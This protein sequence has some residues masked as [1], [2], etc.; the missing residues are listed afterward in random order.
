MVCGK[1]LPFR[2]V[3]GCSAL[4]GAD[5]GYM[6]YKFTPEACLDILKKEQHPFTK[7]SLGVNQITKAFNE[8]LAKLK[9][10]FADQVVPNIPMPWKKWPLLFKII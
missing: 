10:N 5:Y 6:P 4:S 7:L 2:T 3:L 9:N 1:S 8:V